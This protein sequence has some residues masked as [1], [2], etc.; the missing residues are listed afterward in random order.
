MAGLREAHLIIAHLAPLFVITAA[1]FTMLCQPVQDHNEAFSL[2][3]LKRGQGMSADA[4]LVSGVEQIIT[5]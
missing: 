1:E 4:K 2:L 5:P 3:A